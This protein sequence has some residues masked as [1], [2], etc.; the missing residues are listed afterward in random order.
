MKTRLKWLKSYKNLKKII[1]L[2]F[3]N[4]VFS[5]AKNR[6]FVIVALKNVKDGI[7]IRV[8]KINNESVTIFS[9]VYFKKS[10]E[11]FKKISCSISGKVKKIDAEAK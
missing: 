6:Y 9:Q 8:Y 10:S 11:K 3:Q 4:Y 7:Q 1:E 2:N 5:L